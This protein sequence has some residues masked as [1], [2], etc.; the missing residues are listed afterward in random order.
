MV[1]SAVSG[2]KVAIGETLRT[3]SKGNK[4][5]RIDTNRPVTMPKPTDFQDTP[6]VTSTGKKSAKT[7]GK[8][9]CNKVPKIEP[10]AAPIKPIPTISRR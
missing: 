5:N 8:A 9:N 1:V 10:I 7:R 2:R 6:T 3:L 4:A